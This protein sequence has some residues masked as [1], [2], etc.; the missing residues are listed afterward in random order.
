M[1]V[2]D[3]IRWDRPR[4]VNVNHNDFF[5]R[6]IASLQD[7]MNRLFHE[8]GTETPIRRWF[9]D[10][11]AI[12]VVEKGKSFVVKAELPGISP[13]DIEVTVS[14]GYL[15]MKGERKE[16]KEEKD[17]AFLR[18]EISY[19]SFQ[20]TIALPETADCPKAE[21]SFKNGVLTVKVPKT[22]A[23]QKE[24]KKLEIKKAA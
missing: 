23:A 14:D 21:A 8:L 18:R 2:R 9:D 15:I 4:N 17:D 12:D 20:R 13:E 11:P 3:L 19:G 16:E 7:D 5:S 6:S 22:S 24:P 10:A 1:S